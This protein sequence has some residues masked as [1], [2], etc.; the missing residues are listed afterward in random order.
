[1]GKN[2]MILDPEELANNEATSARMSFMREIVCRL[3]TELEGEV[4]QYEHDGV[5]MVRGIARLKT[6]MTII[7]D[8]LVDHAKELVEVVDSESV[9]EIERMAPIWV[10]EIE[11]EFRANDRE[12]ARILEQAKPAHKRAN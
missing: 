3:I 4:L 1:M 7:H 2:Q 5:A 6:C 11:D 9:A 8:G 12:C 10:A